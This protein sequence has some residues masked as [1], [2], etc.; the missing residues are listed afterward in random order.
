MELGEVLSLLEEKNVFLTGG[1]GVGKSFLTN[2]IISHYRSERK[3]VVALGS[4]GVSAVGI[5]GSTIHSFFCFGISEDFEALSS[6]DKKNKSRLKELKK[7][8][9]VTDLIVIDEISMV[10]TTL[11]DMIVYRLES[12]DYQGRILLVGDFYQLPPI[13]KSNNESLFGDLL[14]A[15]ESVAWRGLNLHVLELTKMHRT[16][17]EYFAYILNKIRKGIC[18][19]EVVNL[20]SHFRNNS[21]SLKYE[22]TYLFGRNAEV[23]QTN[24]RKLAAIKGEEVCFTPE[25]VFG[26][27]V[28]ESRLASWKKNLP[29]NEYL[30]LKVG[31]PVLFTVN[32]WGKFANGERGVVREIG[33]NFVIVE[34]ENEYIK[35][36]PHPFD[37]TEIAIDKEGRL[38]S[39]TLA[40]LSQLPIK[41]AYAV[42]IHKSQGMSI[43]GLICDVNHIFATSQFYVAISRAVDPKHLQIIYN[44]HDFENYLQKIIRVDSRVHQYYE[45]IKHL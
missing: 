4:T 21:F 25:I 14:F 24:R 32:K 13:Q 19:D 1:A 27:K 45:A 37:L 28:H 7:I 33:E 15:F 6:L 26:T 40:T 11:F 43:D 44:N 41:L 20:L 2:E 29:I 16:N 12:M 36:E 38:K 22:P 9:E 34:K 42:T 31:A 39:V 30:I 10:S 8:L 23:E 18:D 3:S 5:G 35:V 17:D